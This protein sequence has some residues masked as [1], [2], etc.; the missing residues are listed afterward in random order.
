M[1]LYQLPHAADAARRSGVA[2]VICMAKP[3]SS[4]DCPNS[5][6]DGENFAT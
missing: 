5:Q 6:K 4:P 3:Q 2:A 1:S